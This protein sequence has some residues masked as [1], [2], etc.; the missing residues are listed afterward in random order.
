MDTLQFLSA[1]GLGAIVSTVIQGWLSQRAYLRQ[2]A[3]AEKKESYVG[4]LD[5]LHRSEV[6]GGPDAALFVGHWENRIALVGSPAAIAACE[7]VRRTNPLNGT[8]HPERPAAMAAL[9]EA[10]R[11]DIGVAR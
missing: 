9:K 1:F 4:Y 7:R 10:M 3:F 5:A 8:A 6:E 2:R 11:I